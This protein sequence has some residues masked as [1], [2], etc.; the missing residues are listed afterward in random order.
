[1]LKG[2]KINTAIII[3]VAFLL[4]LFTLSVGFVSSANE[5][6]GNT[7]AHIQVE[8]LKKSEASY[9]YIEFSEE[10]SDDKNENKFH[11]PLLLESLYA[12]VQNN[13]KG[14]IIAITPSNK[15]Y[16][17]NSSKRHLEF[18]VFRI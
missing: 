2:L 8:P 12:P 7:V 14:Q 5:Q 4:R 10:D 18:G 1:M 6:G 15:H 16:V 17:Y 3:C 11:A 9:S 13:V